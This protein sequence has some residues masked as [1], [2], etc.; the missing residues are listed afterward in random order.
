MIYLPLVGFILGIAWLIW[1]GFKEKGDYLRRK[2]EQE[3]TEQ[4]KTRTH[5][6]MQGA[7]AQGYKQ[8]R[9]LELTEVFGRSGQEG[10]PKW[11][12]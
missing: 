6:Q 8:G 7:G 12:Q 3:K 2:A 5:E 10:R 1:R 9:A 4:A 11:K